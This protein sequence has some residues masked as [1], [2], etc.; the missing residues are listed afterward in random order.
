LS[1]DETIVTIAGVVIGPVLW[2]VWLFRLSRVQTLRRRPV[3]VNAIGLALVACTGLLFAVLKTSASFDV[4]DAPVYLF[5]YVVVGLAWLRVVELIFAF[6]GLSVRDDVVERSNRAA[7]PAVV[8]GM[9]AVTLCYAGGNIGD[10]PGWWVVL[11]SAA[12]ATAGLIVAWL[13]LAH[14]TTVVDAVTIDRDA[15][16]GLRLGAFLVACG[17]VLGRGVAGDWIS[18]AAT[19]S[20][21]VVSLPAVAVI[22]AIAALVES[23]SRLTPERPQAPVFESG[24]LPSVVYLLV[25]IAAVAPLGW[26]A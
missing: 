6:L 17:I 22:V 15:A 10:G 12:L 20:D 21:F 11:L 4:V 2:A 23:R 18:A 13:A 8:G 9:I 25:A 3:G 1:P 16:A 24:V 14:L 19:L 26:P 7:M 5:M